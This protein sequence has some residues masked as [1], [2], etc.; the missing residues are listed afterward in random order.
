MQLIDRE[1]NTTLDIKRAMEITLSWALRQLDGNAGWIGQVIENKIQLMA[2]QGYETN[3]LARF[4]DDPSLFTQIAQEKYL[5]NSQPFQIFTN[6]ENRL[7]PL[8]K[9]L[10]LVR[11]QR[12]GKTIALMVLEMLDEKS[13]D[14]NELNFLMRLSDHAS[15]ALINSQ[16]YGEVQAANQA[17]SEFVSLVA[18]ELKNPMTSIKGYT[19]LLVAGAAGTVN[20]AQ[21]NFLMTIRANTERM[22]TLVSDLNDLTKIEAGSMRLESKAIQLS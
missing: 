3:I 13:L 20:D 18:H 21:T 9:T 8:A 7:L 10:I 12:D 11:I 14:E 1:L 15:I 5:N 4:K 19:E 22:N 16:L 2:S 6:Q 17:K